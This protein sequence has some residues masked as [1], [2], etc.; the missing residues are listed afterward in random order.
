MIKPLRLAM[1][2]VGDVAQRDYLPELGRISGHA[3]LAAV[4]G[5]TPTRAIEVGRSH[6]VP[7]FTDV[8]DMFSSIDIDCILNLTPIP[9]HYEVSLSALQAGKH[10]YS[11]K[12]ITTSLEEAHHLRQLARDKGLVIVP[13][14]SVMLF[15]QIAEAKRLIHEGAVGEVT[16]ARSVMSAGP[17][18]WDGYMSDPSPYFAEGAGP[19]VDIGVYGLHAITG[20]LGPAQRVIAL[21][22]KTRTS[23]VV[24]EGPAA[25]TVVAVD[26]DDQWTT[27]LRIGAGVLASV[28]AD[29]TSVGGSAPEL[30]IMGTDRA[31]EVSLLD[32]ASPLHL[33]DSKG[34]RSQITISGARRG[35]GPDHLLGVEHLVRCVIENRQPDVSIEHAIH[36]LE[37]LHAS[38]ESAT[39]GR[40]VDLDPGAWPRPQEENQ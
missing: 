33:T 39:T 26:E 27:C 37:I 17:P 16:G 28:E 12:P 1:V 24:E 10:V 5:R 4:V 23:F 2:G 3:T 7:W 32:G 15:P 22:S 21:S 20:L 36:C 19:L 34:E 14:P 25:G 35:G 38:R 13:A 31:I 40:A 29:F 18:P 9:T 8:D 30:E 11:E 6:G